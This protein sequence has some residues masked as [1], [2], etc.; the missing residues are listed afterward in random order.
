MLI[1]GGWVSMGEILGT[2]SPGEQRLWESQTAFLGEFVKLGTVKAGAESVGIT[3]Q[4]VEYWSQHDCL[5]FQDRYRQAKQDRRDHAEREFVLKRL[6][7][8]K[9]NYGT[10]VLAIAYM[11]RIDPDNWNRGIKVTHD[12]PNELIAQLQR[13]QALE[14]VPAPKELGPGTETEVMPWEQ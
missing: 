12:V 2:L 1:G 7:N 3:R 9:G 4:G 8:P 5:G 10:D 13:L 11:N 6:E 14:P